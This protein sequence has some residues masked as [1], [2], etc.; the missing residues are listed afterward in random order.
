[1]YAIGG[2][3]PAIGIM[4]DLWCLDVTKPVSDDLTWKEIQPANPQFGAS[5]LY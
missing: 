5:S 1:M 4:R 3:D 2:Y